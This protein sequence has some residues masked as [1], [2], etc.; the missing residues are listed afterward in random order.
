M[1]N[2]I[3]YQIFE[4]STIGN[5]DFWKNSLA[6]FPKDTK[7]KSC[8]FYNLSRC[9]D[10][11]YASLQYCKTSD[12]WL[13]QNTLKSKIQITLLEIKNTWDLISSHRNL[14]VKKTVK[15]ILMESC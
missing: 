8:H 1:Y 14:I 13:K 6:V 3:T 12:G 2:K 10:I 9:R 7:F 5:F 11:Q 15:F 4:S